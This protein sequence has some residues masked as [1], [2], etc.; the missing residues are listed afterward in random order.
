MI[1]DLINLNLAKLLYLL[2]LLGAL[3]GILI[4]RNKKHLSLNIQNLAIWGLI[5]FG[6]VMSYQI[7]LE[8]KFS[9]IELDSFSK[10]YNNLPK[11]I[12]AILITREADG[13]FYISL[14]I[15]RKRIKFL[16]DTGAT[17]SMLSK[18]DFMT[19]N[20]P[21]VN[22]KYPF[23]IM[24]ANGKI[25]AKEATVADIVFKNVQ[26]GPRKLLVASD[27]FAGPVI[28]LLGLDLLNSFHNFELSK[29]LLTIFLK[30][31]H[32]ENNKNN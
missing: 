12:K 30:S 26:L 17:R 27:H 9:M 10:E 11:D 2:L 32:N 21:Y 20:L 8:Y 4:L 16:V 15:N 25:N 5:F 22:P 13:H 28:S 29:D 23:K 24:T 1:S 14:S 6:F 19:L 31:N 7:W 3:L 18:N